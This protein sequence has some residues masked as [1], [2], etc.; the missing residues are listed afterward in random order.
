MSGSEKRSI[1]GPGVVSAI[2]PYSPAVQV[3]EW[4]YVSGQIP[5]NPETG[6]MENV[7]VDRAA[8]QVMQNLKAVLSAAGCDFGDVVKSTIY[9]VDLKDFEVVN[10]VYERYVQEPYPARA[11]VQV[12]ALPKE[13]L[14]EIDLIAHCSTDTGEP[15]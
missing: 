1:S 7:L 12:A 2:G 4:L 14:L 10:E 11:T 13:A 3:G 9:L 6:E 5:L 15:S 8:E